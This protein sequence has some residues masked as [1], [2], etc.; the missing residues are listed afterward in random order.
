MANRLGLISF[1]FLSAWCGLVAGL[2]EVGTIVLRKQTFDPNHL[3]EMS[4]HFVWFIPAT[5]LGFFLGLAVAGSLLIVAWP[6]RGRWMATR[7]LCAL[8]L[9][10]M[11]L[12][13]FPRMYGSASLLL[14]L[15]AAARR[16]V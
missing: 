13:A 16:D 8:T 4:R 2:L 1:V 12:V 15:G 6:R 9:L 14:T 5:N 10:P 3:Y 7:F 11:V